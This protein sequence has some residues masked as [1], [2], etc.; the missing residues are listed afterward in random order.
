LLAIH[1]HQPADGNRL[2][3]FFRRRRFR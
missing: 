3:P 1:D 2:L